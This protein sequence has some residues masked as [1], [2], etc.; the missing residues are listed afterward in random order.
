MFAGT[1]PAVASSAI[2]APAGPP[3][4]RTALLE[5]YLP[6]EDLGVLD[7]LAKHPE[8]D[9]RGVIVAILDTGIELGH[10]ALQRTSTGEPKI[11]DVYDATDDGYLALPVQARVGDRDL[12]GLS[13]RA[14][15]LP[16]DVEAGAEARLGVLLGRRNFPGGLQE[17]RERE[18]RDAWQ[19]LR[20]RWEAVSYTH[21][22]A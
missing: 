5:G 8:S 6:K 11:L 17:R 1:A 22:R 21:L 2:S 14:L 12:V 16:S 10:P 20:A 3:A 13:G 4:E 7:F 9:G 19:R 15:V 18:R